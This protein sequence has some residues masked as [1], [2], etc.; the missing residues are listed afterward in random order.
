MDIIQGNGTDTD[1]FVDLVGGGVNFV[2]GTDP[3]F[4]PDPV[5]FS[6]SATAVLNYA[7]NVASARVRVEADWVQF[8]GT[9]TDTE[10]VNKPTTPCAVDVCPNI[11][12]VQEQAPAEYPLQQ[13][14]KCYKVVEGCFNVNGDFIKTSY[15]DDG[16]N[17][18][19]SL[20]GA[21]GT[22]VDDS[23]CE[24]ITICVDGKPV[25]GQRGEL[26]EDTGDCDEVQVCVNGEFVTATEYE[27]NEGLVV[28]TGDCGTV[29]VCVDGEFAQYPE[30]DAPTSTGDCDFVTVCVEGHVQRVTEFEQEEN[31][32]QLG[33][34]RFPDP[35]PTPS[36]TTPPAPTV[37][38]QTP[39]SEVSGAVSAVLPARLPT[40]GSGP[41]ESGSPWLLVLLVGLLGLGGSALTVVRTRQS[42]R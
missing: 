39:V 21:P 28:D 6:G 18:P 2:D 35:S 12:G 1:G 37:V 24:E 29:R 40:T 26:G 15:Q 8:S 11:E 33:T 31:D 17:P 42:R 5:P 34:C 7:S 9:A 41:D 13:D 38:P 23:Q 32:L 30:R 10:T 22:L 25:T 16:P 4:T 3:A 27:V 19:G 20:P 14:G 36:P